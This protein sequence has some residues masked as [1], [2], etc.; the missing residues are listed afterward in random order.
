MPEESQYEDI[1]ELQMK[2]VMGPK[3]ANH[4]TLTWVMHA[5]TTDEWLFCEA[6]ESGRF[7]PAHEWG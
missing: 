4:L 2:K 3:I 6:H 1:S 7:L 5:G